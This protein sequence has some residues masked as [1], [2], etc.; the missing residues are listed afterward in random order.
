MVPLKNAHQKFIDHLKSKNRANATVLAYGKDID[1]LIEFLMELERAH[2]T[3]ISKEDIQAFM[4]KLL[5]KG[6][7]PKSVSRKTNAIKTFF[8]FLKVDEYITDDPALLVSHPKFE[9]KPPRI[10]SETEYRALRDAVRNDVRTY[11]IVELLIQTGIRIGELSR[12]KLDDVTLG[13][14]EKTGEIRIAVFNRHLERTVPL[15]TRSKKALEAY[16]KELPKKGQAK[17]VFITR[18]GKPLLVRNIRATIKRYLELAGIQDATVN[19]LR[20]TFIAQHL[21]RGASLVLVSKIAG[22]RRLSTTEKYLEHIE[23]TAP[24]EKMELAEL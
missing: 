2:I 7:T 20:H 13:K 1:Q 24:A 17:S 16:L 19:D 11:A 6:Y 18:T 23:V 9:T 3:E 14:G 4:A 10:L 8:R 22:H 15:N 12:L 21:K 5:K